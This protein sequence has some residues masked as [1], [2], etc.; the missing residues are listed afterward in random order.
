VKDADERRAVLA[1]TL[2]RSLGILA[3]EGVLV[4]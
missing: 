2:E 3:S 1:A 4:A